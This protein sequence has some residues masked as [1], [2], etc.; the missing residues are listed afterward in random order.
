MQAQVYARTHVCIFPLCGV[1]MR[2]PVCAGVCSSGMC[3]ILCTGTSDTCFTSVGCGRW[4]WILCQETVGNPVLCTKLLWRVWQR[5]RNDVCR[6]NSHVLFPGRWQ[7]KW[8]LWAPWPVYFRSFDSNHITITTRFCGVEF[9]MWG[10]CIT[11]MITVGV[12]IQ[13]SSHAWAPGVLPA[14]LVKVAVYELK[15]PKQTKKQNP[16]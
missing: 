16:I 8:K 2:L 3:F 1:Y 5:R 14:P 15:T 6:W 4:L 12:S 7:L 11:D 13:V 9:I 10:S